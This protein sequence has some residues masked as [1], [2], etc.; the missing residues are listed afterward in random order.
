[1]QPPAQV[2]QEAAT[3]APTIEELFAYPMKG[4]TDQQQTA[5]KNECRLWAMG[6]TG[7]SPAPTANGTS[8]AAAEHAPANSAT[9]PTASGEL[10]G[11]TNGAA[12]PASAASNHGDYLRAEAACLKARGY[13]VE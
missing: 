6:Q 1:M 4:Q 8:A 7:V 13:S 2:V 12:P 10:L 3:Q 9:A 5:D 11:A